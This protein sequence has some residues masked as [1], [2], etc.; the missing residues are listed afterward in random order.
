MCARVVI[1]LLFSRPPLHR[2]NSRLI[3]QNLKIK[4]VYR[5]RS[6][7]RQFFRVICKNYD[8]K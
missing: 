4:N 7:V 3:I 2:T 1:W 6:L 8:L 5:I